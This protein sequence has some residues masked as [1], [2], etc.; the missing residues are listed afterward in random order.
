MPTISVK[1]PFTVLVGVV[2][3]LVLGFIS[4]TKI[5][6]DLLPTISLPYVVAVFI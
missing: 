5:T 1:K 6:T 3:V 4:F 2:M